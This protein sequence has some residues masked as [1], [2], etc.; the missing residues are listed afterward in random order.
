[1]PQRGDPRVNANRSGQGRENLS[2]GTS[3]YPPRD[4]RPCLART[5]PGSLRLMRE[6][7]ESGSA[8]LAAV[9][10]RVSLLETRVE[11]IAEAVEVLAR[12]LE[13]SPIAEPV[14]HPAREAARRAHELLLLAKPG[15]HNG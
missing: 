5:G 14:N 7:A 3:E 9:E 8:A 12:G 2:S 10:R 4:Q 11:A 15:H 1:M 13:G 6:L